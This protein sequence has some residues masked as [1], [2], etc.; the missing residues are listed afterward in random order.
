MP[1]KLVEVNLNE[2]INCERYL[3]GI[4]TDDEQIYWQVLEYDKNKM[5][6]DEFQTYTVDIF[7]CRKKDKYLIFELP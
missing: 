5:W 4:T 1:L 3:C 6:T 7:F 2:L